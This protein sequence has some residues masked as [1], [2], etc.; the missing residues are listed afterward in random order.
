MEC[1]AGRRTKRK[2]SR[3]FPKQARVCVCC[4]DIAAL[5][6]LRRRLLEVPAARAQEQLR[7]EKTCSG[8][9]MPTP[10]SVSLLL[11]MDQPSIQSITLIQTTEIRAGT[12]L[13]STT[14][15]RRYPLLSSAQLSSARPC[16]SPPQNHLLKHLVKP[17]AAPEQ[18]Q[19]LSPP[20]QEP[21][22]GLAQNTN[23]VSPSA[24]SVPQQAPSPSKHRPPPCSRPLDPAARAPTQPVLSR[25][26]ASDTPRSSRS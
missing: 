5:F 3:Q 8:P 4:Y 16:P 23:F 19:A 24:I 10:S 1:R 20:K 7:S 21:S 6:A 26:R 25:Q 2:A 22:P 17:P 18:A 9:A 12:S 11:P 15:F 14:P 13:S